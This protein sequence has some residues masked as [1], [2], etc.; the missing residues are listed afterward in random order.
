MTELPF[1]PISDFQMHNPQK[2]F[3]PFNHWMHQYLLFQIHLSKFSG[4]ALLV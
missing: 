1:E 4:R 3:S 2:L